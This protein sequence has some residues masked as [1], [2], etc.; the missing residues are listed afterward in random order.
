MVIYFL[1]YIQVMIPSHEASTVTVVVV[2]FRL[3]S[4]QQDYAL[5]VTG[6]LRPKY[7]AWITSLEGR[8]RQGVL[9]ACRHRFSK[10]LGVCLS[11]VTLP[12]R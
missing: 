4:A 9:D 5:V 3:L 2:A 6:L 11:A 8:V 10:V 1:L 7:H 12:G